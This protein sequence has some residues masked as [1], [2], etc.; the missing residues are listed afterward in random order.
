MKG[1]ESNRD[2]WSFGVALRFGFEAF[3]FFKLGIIPK[4]ITLGITEASL[5]FELEDA[6]MPDDDWAFDE[7]PTSR[8]EVSSEVTHEQD[9][10]Q[11]HSRSSALEKSA[12]VGGEAQS[13]PKMSL[14]GAFKRTGSQKSSKSNKIR[15]Q[16]VEKF[17]H[18]QHM[19]S[20]S[21]GPYDPCWTVTSLIEDQIL[22]GPALKTSYFARVVPTGDP[23]RVT[24][25]AVIPE[26][27]IRIRD[28][29]GA[30]QSP[31]KRLIGLRRIRKELCNRPIDLHE[32]EIFGEGEGGDERDQ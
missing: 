23:A 15:S 24:M 30:F 17:V 21:G 12:A 19:I 32:A 10:N 13:S 1:T 4:R 3:K 22:R 16:T 27:A 25:K 7:P 8:L 14:S 20:S 26:H 28:H 11:A 5:V 6:M 31:N 18:T 29:T 2:G 9:D